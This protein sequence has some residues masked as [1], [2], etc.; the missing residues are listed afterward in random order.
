MDAWLPPVDVSV[1]ESIK[2]AI[3]YAQKAI[4]LDPKDALVHGFLGYLYGYI[5]KYEDAIFQGEKAVKLSPNSSSA[6]FSLGT[7]LAY[8]G[9]YEEAIRIYKKMFRLNPK[10]RYSAY[11]V[12][13]GFPYLL[14]GQYELAISA[15]IK[16]TQIAPNSP[17][18]Y[19]MLAPTYILSGQ[20][21][22]AREAAEKLLERN[23]EF[24]VLRYEKRSALRKKEDLNRIVEAMRKAG[25]PE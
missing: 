1:S 24:S 2:L 14:T 12:H 11:Y 17:F 10:D 18:P 5:K 22:K 6:H 4:E 25:L 7:A 16:A 9:K 19:M 15:Y 21:N 20:E 13:I 8:D 3:K 23:P